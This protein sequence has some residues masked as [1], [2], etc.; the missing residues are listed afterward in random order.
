MEKKNPQAT[1][2]KKVLE[3]NHLLQDLYPQYIKK[4]H[5]NNKIRQIP[6]FKKSK[7]FNKHFTEEYLQVANNHMYVQ[8]N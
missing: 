7:Q 8:H 4:T 1:D 5:S 2:W 3:N 6:N